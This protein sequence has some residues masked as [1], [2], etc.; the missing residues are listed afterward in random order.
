M[1]YEL[2][3]QIFYLRKM[4]ISDIKTL[5]NFSLFILYIYIK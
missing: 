5:Q 3:S 2:L 4:Y 1:N